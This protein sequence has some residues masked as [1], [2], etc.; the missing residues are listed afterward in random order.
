MPAPN[1]ATIKERARELGFAN[2]LTAIELAEKIVPL[3]SSATGDQ[4]ESNI[5]LVAGYLS[6]ALPVDRPQ[7]DD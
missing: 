5:L 3:V 6:A 4:Q 7:P 1:L 2:I